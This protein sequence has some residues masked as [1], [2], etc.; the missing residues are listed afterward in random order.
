MTTLIEVIE[1]AGITLAEEE[2]ICG[3]T[4]PRVF[5]VLSE[6][7]TL[8]TEAQ[9]QGIVAQLREAVFAASREW[10]RSSNSHT[11]INAT[12]DAA[13]TSVLLAHGIQVGQPAPKVEP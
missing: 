3:K 10:D 11:H 4:H 6:L 13:I 5:A 9:G 2:M 1:R 8:L 7:R 12:Y